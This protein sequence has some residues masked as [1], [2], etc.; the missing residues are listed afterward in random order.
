MAFLAETSVPGNRL[1]TPSIV[2]RC[3]VA[4]CVEIVQRRRDTLLVPAVHVERDGTVGLRR[5]AI[6]VPRVLAARSRANVDEVAFRPHRPA[7][8]LGAAVACARL[9]ARSSVIVRE[10]T[11][12][13]FFTYKAELAWTAGG[14]QGKLRAESQPLTACFDVGDCPSDGRWEARVDARCL[15]CVVAGNYAAGP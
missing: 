9:E 1:R 14:V 5:T 7:P 6:V 8:P 2:I 12:C 3:S 10:R 15:G 13:V 11:V 4:E